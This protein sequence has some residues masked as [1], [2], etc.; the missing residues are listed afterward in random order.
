MSSPEEQES[1]EQPRSPASTGAA[2]GPRSTDHRSSGATPTAPTTRIP[3]QL[4]DPQSGRQYTPLSKKY[5]ALLKAGRK[6]PTEENAPQSSN[7]K[8]R[9]DSQ[10]SPNTNENTHFVS[11]NGIDSENLDHSSD[12]EYITASQLAS[13]L[14]GVDFDD[15]DFE[16]GI[17][18]LD[19]YLALLDGIDFDDENFR[20]DDEAANQDIDE[21]NHQ[22]PEEEEDLFV[23]ES[24][25]EEFNNKYQVYERTMKASLKHEKISSREN[26]IDALHGVFEAMI[27][28]AR[29]GMN[30]NGIMRMIIHSGHLDR[31]ISTKFVLRDELTAELI[32]SHI[33]RILQ[34]HETF[35]IDETFL[36]QIVS[37][38]LPVPGSGRN[39]FFNSATEFSK[40]KQSV[41]SIRN[42]DDL[43]CGR[44]LAVAKA[45]IDKHR[46]WQNIRK[47]RKIQETLARSLYNNAGVPLG[48]CALDEIQM[49]QDYLTGYQIVVVSRNQLNQIIFQG[50][51][52]EDENKKLILYHIKESDKPQAHYDVITS[53]KA[54]LGTAYYCPKCHKGY[55]RRNAHKCENMCKI[56][57]K[58]NCNRAFGD[59]WMYCKDCNRYFQSDQCFQNHKIPN[60]NGV[61]VCGQR[62]KCETCNK[63]HYRFE[64]HKCWARECRFCFKDVDMDHLCFIQP[65]RKKNKG[66][67]K[68]GQN[69]KQSHK[70][71]DDSS[72]SSECE[73][74]C[75]IGSTVIEE[76]EA[77]FKVTELT[78]DDIDGSAK[79]QRSAN[80][81]SKDETDEE[82]EEDL[83]DS[84]DR[85]PS[86]LYFFD[87]ECTQVS[88]E[89]VPILCV[90]QRANTNS[91]I[92]FKGADTTKAFCR[93]V[94]RKEMKHSVFCAH[95]L[96]GYDAH[97]ILKYLIDNAI[98]PRVIYCGGKLM[99]MEITRLKIKFVDSFNFLPMPLAKFPKTFGFEDLTKGWFPHYFSSLENMS[100]E[101]PLPDIKFYA[102][103]T[104]SPENR[105][106]CVSWVTTKK[107]E[108]Y[109]FNFEKDLI[110]YCVIDVRILEQ[111]F[112]T[113]QKTF[114]QVSNGINP[115]E[116]C[117]T[118]ASACNYVYRDLFLKD[119]MIGIVPIHGYRFREKQS[120]DAVEWLKY[121]SYREDKTIHHA[122]NSP[123]EV[124]VCG[125]K[126][127]GFEKGAPGTVYEYHGCFWHGCPKCFNPDDVN[128]VNETKMWELY[129][130]TNRKADILKRNFN[131]VEM[132]EHDFVKV[133]TTD[134]YCTYLQQLPSGQSTITASERAGID[135]LNP[136]DGFFGGRTN[137][138]S[139]YAKAD[140]EAG[141]TIQ[142]VDFTSL[143]P[144]TNK[145]CEYPLGHPE[146]HV[147]NFADISDYYGMAK[148]KVLP[149]RGLFHPVLPYR[150]GDKLMF[151]LCH[152]C[153]LNEQKKCNHTDEERSLV[154]TWVT[155]EL[156]K[157]VE[158][159]Y[160]V[161][162]IYEVHH[163]PKKTNTLFTEYIDTFLKLKQESSGW[164]EWVTSAPPE[165]RE[166]KENEYLRKYEENEGIRL[167]R[168]NIKKNPGMRTLSKLCLN[169]FWGKFGQ[170]NNFPK[171]EYV[172]SPARLYELVGSKTTDIKSLHIVNDEIVEVHYAY[173]KD[174]IPESA[175]TNVY[176]A[177]FTTA[178]ARLKLYDSLNRLGEAVLYFD[179]DSIIYR[180]NGKNNLELGDYL[181]E[182]TNEVADNGG[183]IVQYCSGGPKNYSYLCADG[184]SV[185][186]VRGFSLNYQNQQLI[187]FDVMKDMI[188]GVGP[189]NIDIVTE[190]KIS[191][192]KK[193]KKVVNKREVKRYRLVYN[194]RVIQ[195]NFTTLPYGY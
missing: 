95:N 62:L 139:F 141:E 107:Q 159:G 103:D 167:D 31:C 187:N 68:K 190:R 37:V 110:D 35:V 194:K 143:Y 150:V 101:G 174:F 148:C 120:R 81:S 36:V 15:H 1:D 164:P 21:N 6:R 182:F 128:P 87:F 189:E 71:T 99:S 78:L 56:C 41:I 161:V 4:T 121:V 166:A 85:P 9:H 160:K 192:D 149:P 42:D 45:R 188:M 168:D 70:I 59:K 126:V 32:L 117:I 11:L 19:E 140:L 153:S 98:T 170:R 119:N 54:F 79:Q 47:G 113:F 180:C 112:T 185:C 181:G 46:D 177:A 193:A 25:K 97:F 8:I 72:D 3:R 83:E 125:F 75:S 34:S 2:P 134:E 184:S 137:A 39:P 64:D 13:L 80:R 145:Y 146:V 111:G 23:V 123:R 114:E 133:K 179:T 147:D 171:T 7:K 169:S 144:W 82:E 50:P 92:Y 173:Q 24:V 29:E 130:K 175:N 65:L 63:L 53:M 100:Y 49:F 186:K 163:F 48:P 106:N 91:A 157:A 105:E 191:R 127:D 38:N 158:M 51:A 154:G 43:C 195:D 151:P 5:W 17:E 57:E 16:N 30:V 162:E 58:K 172:T 55:N 102:V 183:Y 109:V 152:T 61:S 131:Y 108:G 104:M 69:R 132:W 60:K 26:M 84:E 124:V 76:N 88:G 27:S 20:S 135:F 122:K 44:A 116:K 33:E 165:E 155:I 96:K 28:R 178:H 14:E 129:A 115:I 136:R 10:H 156:N 66:K 18:S 86:S 12:N 73:T 22:R 118:I 93:W 40:K 74:E 138:I 176:I 89:H 94:L 52:V 90:V 77:D 67:K 142:Y